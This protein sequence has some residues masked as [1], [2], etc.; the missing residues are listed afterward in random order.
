[1]KIIIIEG[2]LERKYEFATTTAKKSVSQA[3]GKRLWR[4][5]GEWDRVIFSDECKVMIGESNRLYVRRRPG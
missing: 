1:M 4:V 2:S 5:E 3:R